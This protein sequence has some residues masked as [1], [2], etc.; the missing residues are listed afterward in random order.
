MVAIATVVL[1]ACGAPD[2]GLLPP[3]SSTSSTSAAP[4][5]AA[6]DRTQIVLEPLPGETTTTV[7]IESGRSTLRGTV[8]GPDGG[9]G[10]AIVR[11]ERLVGDAVQRRDVP[12]GPGGVFILA[13][14]PGGRYRLRA[15][16][17]P[18]LAMMQP[19]VFYLEDGS[20]RDIDLRTEVFEGVTV[21]GSTTP[22]SPIVGDAV[23]VAVRVAQR[24]VDA[25]G[26]GREVPS[27][28]VAV[29]LQTSGFTELDRRP[30]PDDDDDDEDEGD[31]GDDGG[32]DDDDTSD[33]GARVTDADG[34]I[35]FQFRCDR[36]GSTTATAVV[37]SGADQQS[38]PIEVPPCAPVPT[39]TTTTT[40]PSEG[41]SGDATTTTA[42]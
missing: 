36:V 26:V 28:G 12:T 27:P 10:G 7:P 38:F 13:N 11:V 20:E 6:V 3:P 15:F 23:N 25:D 17:A 31:D 16:L 14:V 9:A 39:T 29:R 40:A 30:P 2:S 35:V 37:G 21:K 8:V 34:V 42:P 1:A 22:S 18:R 32:G 24:S 5:T 19:E 4:T 41:G 33:P